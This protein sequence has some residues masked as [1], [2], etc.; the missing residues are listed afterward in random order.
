MCCYVYFC[1][2]SF[3]STSRFISARVC[4]VYITPLLVKVAVSLPLISTD[5]FYLGKM[6]VRTLLS[7]LLHAKPFAAVS[8]KAF[9][10]A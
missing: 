10:L 2:Y 3:S 8:A 9:F 7:N 5:L 6:S 4:V 1:S